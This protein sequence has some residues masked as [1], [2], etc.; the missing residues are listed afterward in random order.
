MGREDSGDG[1]SGEEDGSHTDN[2]S[3]Q[4]P[5]IFLDSSLP[6]RSRTELWRRHLSDDYR[7]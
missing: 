3:E 2:L 6:L 4:L 7:K 5:P 1:K